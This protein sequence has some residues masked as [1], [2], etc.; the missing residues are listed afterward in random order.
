MH[1]RPVAPYLFFLERILESSTFLSVAVC[2]ACD[3]HTQ[4]RTFGLVE[5]IMP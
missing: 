4:L 5:R 3:G 2:D 1:G